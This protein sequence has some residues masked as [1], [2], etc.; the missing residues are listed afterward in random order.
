M[1]QTHLTFTKMHGLGN[2]FMVINAVDRPFIAQPQQIARWADRHTGIGFDQL[3]VISAADD[4]HDIDFRYHIFNTD[5]SPAGNCGNGAR[6]LAR[7]ALEQGLTTQNHLTIQTST[8][9]MFV[10][11]LDDDQVAVNMGIPRFA[12][13]ELPFLVEHAI[14][15]DGIM[16]YRVEVDTQTIALGI[17]SMGNPHAVVVV[18][19]VESCSIAHIGPALQAHAAFPEQVNVSFMQVLTDSAIRLRVY[20]RGVGE[21]RACG[22]GAC[23]AV[24]IGQATGLLAPEVTVHLAGGDL[25]IAR[26]DQH[27]LWMTGSATTVYHGTILLD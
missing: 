13:P 6:C 25:R 14:P 10:H 5:G 22:T 15:S 12:A 2:D 19:N 23:A 3:L 21:T 16:P 24:A 17:A 1:S 20:E 11:L 8:T 18:D 9:T 26:D 4:L 7:F 27:R